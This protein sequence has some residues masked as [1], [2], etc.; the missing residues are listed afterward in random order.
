[1]LFDPAWADGI[2]EARRITALAAARQLPVAPHD[3]AGPVN[4]ATGVH[5]TVSALNAFIQEGVRAFYRGWYTELVTEVP[6]EVKDRADA[7]IE[8][9][10]WS[11]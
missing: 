3:C 11:G 10:R 4:F 2:T 7:E 5:L 8:V 1:M 6:P 9:S